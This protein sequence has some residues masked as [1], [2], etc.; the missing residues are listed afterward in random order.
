[1]GKKSCHCHK[2]TKGVTSV[3]EWSLSQHMTGI[4]NGHLLFVMGALIL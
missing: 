2:V 1:M 3:I 4:T